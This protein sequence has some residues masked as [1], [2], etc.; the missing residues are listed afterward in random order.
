VSALPVLERC[1]AEAETRFGGSRLAGKPDTTRPWVRRGIG[2]A[3]GMKNLGYSFGFPEQSTATVEVRGRGEV[4]NAVVRVGAA[5]VGQGSH[6]AL[7]QIASEVLSLPFDRIEMI[8][9][10]SSEAPNAGSASASRL[11]LMAGRAVHDAAAKALDHYRASDDERVE[12]TVQF[13]PAATTMLSEDDGSGIPNYCY[14]YAAQ[15]VEVEVD[16]LTGQVRVTRVISVHDVGRAVNMQQVEGQIEGCLAQAVGYALL[17]ELKT[18]DGIILT[19]H[20]STYLLPTALDMPD[21]IVP[22]VLE[23]ADQQGPFGARGVAE[24]PLVPFLPAVASA[25]HDA[26]GVWLTEQPFT[27]ERVLASLAAAEAVTGDIDAK[28]AL[29]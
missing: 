1:A 17:E 18:R 21:E 7:R 28:G 22:V 2:I 8:T 14:G 4:E 5:D 6:L 15:A 10:D 3:A 25:I 20:L 9:D 29:A 11:T 23:L 26:I 13:R 24:M 27:P 19:P 12:A 16:T